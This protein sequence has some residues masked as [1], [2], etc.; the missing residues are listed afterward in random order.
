MMFEIMCCNYIIFNGNTRAFAVHTVFLQDRES[1]SVQTRLSVID[2]KYQELL[3][4][5]KL[6]KQR[7]L[8]ALSLYKL[9]NESDGV[10]T[11]IDEKVR[12]TQVRLLVSYCGSVEW[13]YFENILVAKKKKKK[14]FFHYDLIIRKEL[15]IWF[16]TIAYRKLLSVYV[17]FPFWFWGQDVGSDCIGSWSLLIILLWYH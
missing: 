13:G 5:A 4:F 7:L 8:D 2:R 16:T 12:Y 14:V 6:R 11:W 17:L 1:E 9:F 15:F 10:E 3:E